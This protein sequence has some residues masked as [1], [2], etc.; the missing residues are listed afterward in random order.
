[1]AVVTP[2]APAPAVPVAAARAPAAPP[3]TAAPL[4]PKAPD[5]WQAA[6]NRLDAA[7]LLSPGQAMRLLLDVKGADERE[8]LA[9]F[10]RLLAAAAPHSAVA[11]GVREGQLRWRT[12]SKAVDVA[13]ASRLALQRCNESLPLP[14]RVVL[15]D[16]EFSGGAFVE[17][18]AS[19]GEVDVATVRSVALRSVANN[20]R[21]WREQQAA[22]AASAVPAPPGVIAP[23]APTPTPPAY[24]A[25]P[26]AP[27]PAATPG[28]QGPTVTVAPSPKAQAE[29]ANA[30]SDWARAQAALRA[31]P[32]PASLADSLIVLL[33]AQSDADVDTLRRF[34]SAMKRLR[35]ISALAM[36]ESRNGVI[37]Y[38][39][40]SG[41]SKES[42]AQESA[43]EV[44]ARA[45]S[46]P[47][48][49]VF[50]NGDAR[51]AELVALAGKLSSRSQAAVRRA[52]VES[53]KQ[54]LARGSGF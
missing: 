36:G 18:T 33:G 22:A 4:P 2:R 42:W 51:N 14:C 13:T 12:Q 48:S 20:V 37:A 24:G 10:D 7:T 8:L 41:A 47:C 54:T 25:A 27:A 49:V 6:R 28:P 43:L 53:A 34:G 29:T 52:F 1:M 23:K 15:R 26:A 31:S 21:A 19:L 45:T 39:Y 3:V 17:A 38:G 9:D 30:S 5:P 46:S 32:G 16:G 50:V 35:W 11:F 40:A 44:C